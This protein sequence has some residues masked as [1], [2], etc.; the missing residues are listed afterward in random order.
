ML[1]VGTMGVAV[2]QL[3][4]RLSSDW[5]FLFLVTAVDPFIDSIHGAEIGST[6]SVAR[7][8]AAAV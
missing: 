3:A 4:L 5:R 7:G 2:L 8:A 1:L 6:A